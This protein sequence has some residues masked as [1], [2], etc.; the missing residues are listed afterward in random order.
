MAF[1]LRP[2]VGWSAPRCLAIACFLAA[3][4]LTGDLLASYVKRRGGV[5]DFGTLLPGHGGI[6]DRFDSLLFVAA[7]CA[8]AAATQVRLR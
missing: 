1:L 4:S 3:A 7:A 8:V 5:K 6:L 2:V